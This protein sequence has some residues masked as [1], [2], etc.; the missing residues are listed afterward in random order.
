MIGSVW[1]VRNNY[2]RSKLVVDNLNVFSYKL[3]WCL[4][5]LTLIESC[6]VLDTADVKAW[7][8]Y[9]FNKFLNF[10]ENAVS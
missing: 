6:F 3:S 2:R 8:I 4:K 1:W 7:E 9:Y 10:F 5:K